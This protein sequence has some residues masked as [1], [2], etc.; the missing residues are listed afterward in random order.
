[1]KFRVNGLSQKGDDDGKNWDFEI[2]EVLEDGRRILKNSGG[3]YKSEQ[4]AR[5]AGDSK[6][7]LFK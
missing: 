1:M 6:L 3:G 5:K 7:Y 4:E 2:E